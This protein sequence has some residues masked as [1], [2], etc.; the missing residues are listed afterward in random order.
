MKLEP[1]VLVWCSSFIIHH[2]SFSIQRSS[3]CESGVMLRAWRADLHIHTCLSPCA[4]AEMT[5]QA[6]ARRARQMGLDLIAVCDHN[7]GENAEA[8]A[9]AGR[10]EG[11]AVILGIEVTTREE[12]HILGLLDCASALRAVEEAIYAYLQGRNEPEVFGQQVVVNEYD[13]VVGENV[14]LLIGACDLA[15]DE[16]VGLIVSYNGCAIASHIDREAFGLIGQ[17]GF[18]PDMPLDGLEVSPRM[19]VEEAR[20]KFEL[21]GRSD[22]IRSSDAHRL[23]EIGK[24]A[25]VFELAA[26]TV[27]EIRLA[28]EGLEGRRIVEA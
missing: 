23:E 20:E 18:V 6:I 11:L 25:T 3:F 28:L 4:E 5:P 1:D 27:R 16:V 9:A 24:V 17:L 14:R 2:S 7:S 12:V 26:P 8:V 19:T 15:L 10:R 22:M 21:G 13:E